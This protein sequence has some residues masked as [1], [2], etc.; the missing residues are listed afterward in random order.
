MG[1]TG[2]TGA[3][4]GGGFP[5]GIHQR[6]GDGHRLYRPRRRPGIPSRGT[7]PDGDHGGVSGHHR[8]LHHDRPGDFVQRN[9]HSLRTGRGRGADHP[10]LFPVLRLL[11]RGAHR[12]GTVRLRLCHGAGLGA[13]RRPVR[14]IP[15]WPSRVEALCPFA[16]RHR[17]FG[18][19]AENRHGLAPV[20]DRQRPHGHSQSDR[21]CLAQPG[22]DRAD[23][24]LY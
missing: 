2:A 18:S 4:A 22:F 5:G 12:G 9:P 11:G 3:G 20:R 17:D 8:D 13:L 6:S 16:G 15:L 19:G 23:R 14:R 21:P 1:A 24:R 10:S 7:G